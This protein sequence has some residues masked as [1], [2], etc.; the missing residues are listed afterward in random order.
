[1]SSVD[2]V[3][4]SSSNPGREESRT[5]GNRPRLSAT[6]RVPAFPTGCRASGIIVIRPT[7]GRG[8][9]AVLMVAGIA[10]SAYLLRMLLPF[11]IEQEQ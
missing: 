4:D 2:S 1:M 3:A 11:F 5:I 8:V 9:A 6:H 10:Y 7:G